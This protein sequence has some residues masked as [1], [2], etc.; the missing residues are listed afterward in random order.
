MQQQES[1]ACQEYPA[2]HDRYPSALSQP[3]VRQRQQLSK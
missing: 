1:D 3:D 2:H